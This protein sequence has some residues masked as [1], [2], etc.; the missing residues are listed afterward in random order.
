MKR[1]LIV[2]TVFAVLVL[3]TFLRSGLTAA[4]VL[5]AMSVVALGGSGYAIYRIGRAQAQRV[6]AL[7]PAAGRAVT[8]PVQHCDCCDRACLTAAMCAP[9]PEPLVRH[10]APALARQDSSATPAQDDAAPVL[11]HDSP[12]VA[13]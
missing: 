13:P 8:R 1:A 6:A 11:S 3:L 4:L 10:D 7:A 12:A 5:A 9:G 2:P